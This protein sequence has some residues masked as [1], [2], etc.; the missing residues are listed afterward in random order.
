MTQTEEADQ[1]LRVTTIDLL[2][3][4]KRQLKKKNNTILDQQERLEQ[5]AARIQEVNTELQEANLQL[6]ELSK[7]KDSMI[8]MIVHDLKNPLNTIMVMSEMELDTKPMQIINEA[9]TRM[10][11]LVQNI[12]DI[13]KFENSAIQLQLVWV[14]IMDMLQNAVDEIQVAADRKDLVVEIMSPATEIVPIEC[15][16]PL[17]ERVITNILTNAVKYTSR[18]GAITL[19]SFMEPTNATGAT[20]SMVHVTIRDTGIG[21]PSEKL[22]TIFDKFE[23]IE[24]V[25]LGEARSTGL[26]LTFCK[27]VVET[28]GG[29]IWAESVMGEGSTFHILLPSAQPSVS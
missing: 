12:L 15:D 7:F 26:G 10:L 27:M 20:D 22:H 23:Q 8:G 13:Q 1:S 2:E 29:N 14:P 17:M 9:S 24:A 28:H 11:A 16:Q 18:A 4:E 6:E 5:Q 21:I 25:N 3:Q 19:D